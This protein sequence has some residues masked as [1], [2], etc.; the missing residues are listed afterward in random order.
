MRVFGNTMTVI[1]QDMTKKSVFT[2]N[3]N[4]TDCRDNSKKQFVI[5]QR[6][7]YAQTILPLFLLLV[8]D[9][10]FHKEIQQIAITSEFHDN[11]CS[12]D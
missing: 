7:F 11:T 8:N 3:Q 1:T 4:N 6:F 12:V 5:L 10:G 9:V 2:K